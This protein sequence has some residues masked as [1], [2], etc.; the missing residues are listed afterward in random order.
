M[1]LMMLFVLCTGEDGRVLVCLLVQDKAHSLP[2]HLHYL[3]QL[4][5]PAAQMSVWIHC[6]HSTDNSHDI[7]QEWI[8]TVHE[9]YYDIHVSWDTSGFCERKHYQMDTKSNHHTCYSNRDMWT[10]EYIMHIRQDML[11]HAREQDMDYVLFTEPD[12]ILVNDQMLHDLIEQDKVVIAPMLES[13]RGDDF[14]NVVIE[15]H[16]AE[17]LELLEPPYTGCFPVQKVHSTFLIHLGNTKSL[18]L[19]FVDDNDDMI[20]VDAFAESSAD[21]GITLYV[22]NTDQYGWMPAPGDPQNFM[23]LLL[24]NIGEAEALE[25]LPY[26]NISYPEPTKF[27]FDEIYVINLEHRIDRKA[28]MELIFQ[29][30]GMKAIFTAAVNGWM[31]NETDLQELGVSDIPGWIDP[32]ENRPL[33]MGEIGCF[34][35]HWNIWKHAQEHN[36]TK[37]LILEDDAHF[38]THFTQ[39]FN[40]VMKDLELVPDWDLLYLSRNHVRAGKHKPR[41]RSK[42]QNGW[43]EYYVRGSDKLVY[44]H[45][46][47]WC[48]AYV[49]S[50]HGLHKLLSVNPL[51][52]MIPIDEYLP[53]LYSDTGLPDEVV[54]QFISY[55]RLVAVASDDNLI[56]PWLKKGMDNNL[57]SN[58]NYDPTEVKEDEEDEEEEEVEYDEKKDLAE[59]ENEEDDKEYEIEGQQKGGQE[60]T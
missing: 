45:Y 7:I 4:V 59:D 57:K 11:M 47:Y 60:D 13:A 52:K 27:G 22:L 33:S 26:I 25:K 19:K 44:P 48:N 6:G 12:N 49:L 8:D 58:T 50:A 51:S 29:L 18:S 1:V 40:E 55:P 35:S 21:A 9:D 39:R 37:V 24:Q 54:D 2:Y 43:G 53:I 31:L 14:T 17:F 42:R 36:Y 20:D 46:S 38:M 15:E 30:L 23:H 3:Q 5:Y 41:N 56:N 16:Y 32:C 28:K 34:L 10:S